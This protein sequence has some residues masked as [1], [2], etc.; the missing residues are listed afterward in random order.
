LVSL[1]LFFCPQFFCLLVEE[2]QWSGLARRRSAGFQPAVSQVFNLQ[3]VRTAV[4]HRIALSQAN[5]KSE[6]AGRR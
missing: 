3:G 4:G 6:E 1:N 2:F 5:V